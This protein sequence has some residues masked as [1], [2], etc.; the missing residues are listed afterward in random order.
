MSQS[1]PSSSPVSTE[2]LAT[3]VLIVGAGPAGATTSLFLAKAQIPHTIVDKAR[4]PRGK[5]DGNVYGR[6]V[7]DVL[8]QL[9]PDYGPELLG[10][11]DQVLG[12]QAAEIFTPNGGSFR[13]R[14]SQPLLSQTRQTDDHNGRVAKE[15]FFTMKRPQ[16]DAFLVSKFDTQY[17]HLHWESELTALERTSQGW[18][19]ILKQGNQQ[20]TLSPK[21]IIAADGAN[22]VVVQMLGLKRSGDRYYETIQGYFKGVSGFERDRH[23]EGHFLPQVNPG[24]LFLAPLADGTVNVGIGKLR[25]LQQ[26]DQTDLHQVLQTAIAQHPNLAPR[27]A[28]SELV[29][30]LQDWP[31]VIGTQ[32]PLSLSGDG[33]LLTGDAAGLCN[34]LTR[35]G[36]GNAMMSGQ[37][38]AQ[39]AIRAVQ[40]GLFNGPSLVDYDRAV[41]QQLQ[42]EFTVSQKLEQ[43]LGF[44][45]IFNQL[46]G[47]PFK[48]LIK[49][50]IKTPLRGPLT[51][52]KRM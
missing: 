42:S 47:G 27:F 6:K 18:S 28:H 17:A 5:V 31:E 52:L 19:V 51:M 23:I 36:T 16:F 9:D 48:W 26:R 15:P 8:N 40:S 39:Q 44:P 22:S 20:Q 7:M 41:Y 12:C 2:L 29:E 46:G 4:F 11:T 32:Q 37:A 24:F 43:L 1:P 25:S 10:Q 50:L 3:D 13:L 14:F 35:F 38:A 33:Y 30:A 49:T 21:L 45:M 34:P